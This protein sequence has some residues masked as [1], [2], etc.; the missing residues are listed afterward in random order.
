M[1]IYGVYAGMLGCVAWN[2][3]ITRFA[4]RLISLS[5]ESLSLFYLTWKLFFALA[6]SWFS[7]RGTH[8]CH[9]ELQ[10][11]YSCDRKLNFAQLLQ[12]WHIGFYQLVLLM[13][14]VISAACKKWTLEFG[15]N[16]KALNINAM[17]WQHRRV[18]KSHRHWMKGLISHFQ[19][20]ANKFHQRLLDCQRKDQSQNWSKTVSKLSWTDLH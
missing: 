3:V 5:H 1:L 15:F 16:S 19:S 2:V 6:C 14:F 18:T 13:V 17:H 11:H 12:L 10:L 8:M 20:K 7:G 9:A 4:T